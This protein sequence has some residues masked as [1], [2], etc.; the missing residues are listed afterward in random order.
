MRYKVLYSGYYIIDADSA[1]EAL[2][3]NRDDAE[4]EFEEWENTDAEMFDGGNDND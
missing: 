3:T 4:V 2:E 1:D